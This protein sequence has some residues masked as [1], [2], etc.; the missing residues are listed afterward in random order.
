MKIAEMIE[1]LDAMAIT[2]DED[3]DCEFTHAFGS[4][5]MS[6]V[7]CYSPEKCLMITGL[8]N[9]HCLRTAEMTGMQIILFVR[10]KLPTKEMIDEARENG[11]SLLR[12]SKTMF[13]VCGILYQNGI[14]PKRLD[15]C[16]ELP[17]SGTVTL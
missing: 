8:C 12:T 10:S 17:G 13:E 5:L 14:R 16:D 3:A 9:I 11:I 2:L 6:D 7:L 4:D 15:G 1:L